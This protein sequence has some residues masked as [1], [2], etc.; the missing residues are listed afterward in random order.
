MDPFKVP[1]SFSNSQVEEILQ[2]PQDPDL[3]ASEEG[4]NPLM[5]PIVFAASLGHTWGSK[6]PT[7]FKGYRV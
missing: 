5:L 4:D 3:T 2:R 7:A 6:K 1:L